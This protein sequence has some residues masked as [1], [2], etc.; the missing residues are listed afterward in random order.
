MTTAFTSGSSSVVNQDSAS[1]E[2]FAGDVLN[3]DDED[4]RGSV[5][6]GDRRDH[7]SSE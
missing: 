5:A 1:V 4:A 7:S 3:L 6:E 2:E